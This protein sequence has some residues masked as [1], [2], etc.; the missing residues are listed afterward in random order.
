MLGP[1]RSASIEP[2]SLP[3]ALAIGVPT[4]LL[5]GAIAVVFTKEM[6]VAPS[7]VAGVLGVLS[8][9]FLMAYAA[10]NRRALALTFLLSVGLL[11]IGGPI[12]GGIALGTK[13]LVEGGVDAIPSAIAA[14][15]VM[16]VSGI[17]C[18]WFITVPVG[19][20]FGAVNVVLCA[21]VRAIVKPS[22]S[23]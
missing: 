21:I 9:G 16:G 17:A 14:P 8:S 5:G 23:T 18:G 22:A 2:W 6:G 1:M 4:G 12:V 10:R 3:R 13:A 11:F 15:F 19:V 20:G 7:I